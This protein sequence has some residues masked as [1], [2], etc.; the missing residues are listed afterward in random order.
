MGFLGGASSKELTCQCRR[1]K[2]SIPSLG[3]S[4]E[5]G[6]SYPLQYS[7][8]ENFM[9]KKPGGLWTIGL[10]RAGCDW[11]DWA[12][13]Q[14]TGW[15]LDIVAAVL[16][17]WITLSGGNQLPRCEDTGAALWG[18]HMQGTEASCSQPLRETSWKLSILADISYVWCLG[19]YLD[20]TLM[21]DPPL[22]CSVKLLTNFWSLEKVD[23][24]ALWY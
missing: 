15:K 10:Q 9:D 19:W 20:F 1:S 2:G 3:R 18:A 11:S 5:E 16:L 17:S 21:E 22:D 7:C 24:D 14:H 6:N 13:A 4:L 23:D 8:L 12:Q